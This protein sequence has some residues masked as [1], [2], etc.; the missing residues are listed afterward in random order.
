MSRFFYLSLGGPRSWPPLWSLPQFCGK[1]KH[2]VSL[3]CHHSGSFPF[4]MVKPVFFNL[5]KSIVP[6]P[7][8]RSLFPPNRPSSLTILIP[9]IHCV[10][11]DGLYVYLC[12]IYIRSKIFCSLPGKPIF[13]PLLRMYGFTALLCRCWERTPSHTGSLQAVV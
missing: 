11:A 9:Q 4:C 5:F 6:H 13:T 1:R 12:F 8:P 2:G 3:A 7:H 10:S